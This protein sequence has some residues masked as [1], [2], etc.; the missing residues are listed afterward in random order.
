MKGQAVNYESDESADKPIGMDDLIDEAIAVAREW[1]FRV[2]IL[3]AGLTGWW[4]NT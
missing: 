3:L 1:R 4:L 2:C